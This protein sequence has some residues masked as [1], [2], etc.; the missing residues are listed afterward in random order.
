MNKE[1][2][3]VE[4]PGLARQELLHRFRIASLLVPNIIPSVLGRLITQRILRITHGTHVVV[5]L[6]DTRDPWNFVPL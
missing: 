6:K 2:V 4:P 3:R 1:L 5:L